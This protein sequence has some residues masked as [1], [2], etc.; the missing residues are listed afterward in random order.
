LGEQQVPAA[1]LVVAHELVLQGLPADDAPEA[2]AW[3]KRELGRAG[4]EQLEQRADALDGGE[5]ILG[6][7]ASVRGPRAGQVLGICCGPSRG[8][9]GQQAEVRHRGAVIAA[10]GGAI[11]IVL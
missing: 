1:H 2:Q 8:H 10:A 6:V 4:A 5:A 11:A 9:L 7:H 3:G